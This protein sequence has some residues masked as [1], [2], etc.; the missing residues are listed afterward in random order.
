MP[1]QWGEGTGTRLL[2]RGLAALPA[3]ISRLTVGV[4]PDNKI[5]YAFY[6]THGFEKVGETQVAVNG[7]HYG[8]DLLA[9]EV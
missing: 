9:C 1:E 4:L 7:T 6:R 3:E 2:N 5:G 8:I